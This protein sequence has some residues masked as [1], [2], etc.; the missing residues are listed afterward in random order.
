MDEAFKVNIS[1]IDRRLLLDSGTLVV[2]AQP[3][4]LEYILGQYGYN[5]SVCS[6]V[7]VI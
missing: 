4:I 2:L 7:Y 3:H 1:T 6:D 5:R